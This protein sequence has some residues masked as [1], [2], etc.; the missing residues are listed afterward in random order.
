MYEDLC[1]PKAQAERCDR[2]AETVTGYLLKHVSPEGEWDEAFQDTPIRERLYFALSF[3]RSNQEE[4]IRRANRLIQKGKDTPCHFSSMI[5][6]QLLIKYD[7]YLEKATKEWLDSY[8]KHHMSEFQQHDLDYLGVNDNFPSMAAY[9][10]IMGGQYLKR[11]ELVQ[12]GKER[13]KQFKALFTRRGTASEYNSPTYS[14]IQLLAMAEL[15]NHAEDEEIRKIAQGC[16]TRI[17]A[18]LFGH[19]HKETSQV[20]G[21]YSRA[22]SDDSAGY[23]GLVRSSLY[24]LLGEELSINIFNTILETEDGCSDGFSHNGAAYGQI[25]TVWFL[26]TVYE[27]PEPLIDLTLHKQYPYEMW[28][29]T[30]FTSSTDA[31]PVAPPVW[32]EGELAN[33][34]YPAGNGKIYT[35]MTEDYAM[36]TATHEFHNGIQTDSFHI[37]YQRTVPALRQKDIGA[38]YARYL[39][40]EKMP[41]PEMV[42]LEDDGRKLGIQHKNSAM[43]LYKPKAFLGKGVHSLKLSLV[44]PRID[45]QVGEVWLGEQRM[46]GESIVSKEPCT[47]YIQ[48]GPVYMA[49]QPLLLTNHGR[50]NAVT[51][52]WENGF[53]LISFYNYS[54]AARDFAMKDMLLTGNGFLAEVRCQK[55]AGSFEEFRKTA[56]GF[57]VSDEWQC[58]VHSRFS[59]IRKTYCRKGDLEFSCEY[60]PVSEGIK[61]I[62]VNGQ[63]LPEDKIYMSGFDCTTLPFL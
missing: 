50:E 61:Q 26:D 3:I 20:A 7:A 6:L 45:G 63:P 36:G 13:L 34:E 62:S 55:E 49:F 5:A 51:A 54:G 4:A 57:T 30:E 44:I 22:Y 16:E 37:L 59:T 35:Y 25:N 60:S 2:A 17:W 11:P 53:L 9:T 46:D 8:V 27:C 42:L 43:V 29:T 38:V 48:D 1:S 56:A 15:V 10:L 33:Y 32:P 14:S 23:T 18:D 12:Q 28:A 19:L 47:V 21:P 40:N 31:Q 41:S 58:T 24:A 39:V 52:R